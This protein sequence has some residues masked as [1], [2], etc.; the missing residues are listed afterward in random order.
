MRM[1][2]KL[3]RP[4]SSHLPLLPIVSRWFSWHSK[5]DMLC[6]K[7]ERTC[8]PKLS[9]ALR[10]QWDRSVGIEKTR[11]G[12]G[13]GANGQVLLGL[14][15]VDVNSLP[16]DNIIALAL[17]LIGS[18]NAGRVQQSACSCLLETAMSIKYFA[19]KI[20]PEVVLKVTYTVLNGLLQ[21]SELVREYTLK[22]SHLWFYA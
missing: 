5:I 8:R 21:P 18:V 9:I 11:Y 22:V 6:S 3:Y 17:N 13:L 20:K 10:S 15:Q 2:A 12:F 14:F 19:A 16:L 4:T 7:T 1:L